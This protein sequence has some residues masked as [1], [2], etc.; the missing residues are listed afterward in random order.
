MDPQDIVSISRDDLSGIYGR[1]V[2]GGEGD[3]AV[4][5]WYR[6]KDGSRFPVEVFRR[7]VPSEG[8]H[9]IVAVVRDVT[10]RRAAEEELRRFRLAMDK[11]ADMIVLI[12]RTTM[13]F[14][15]VNDT[16]CRLL[17]YSREELLRMGPQDVLPVDRE[18]LERSY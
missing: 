5:G 15:D 8:G 4:G 13:R 9:V 1:L 11:S 10:E 12:D 14:L 6:R 16:A 18:E 17:G 3:T 2:E 7:S